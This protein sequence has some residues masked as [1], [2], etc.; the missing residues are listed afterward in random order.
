MVG[1]HVGEYLQSDHVPVQVYTT[2]LKFI[3]KK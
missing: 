2:C 1:M 3:A